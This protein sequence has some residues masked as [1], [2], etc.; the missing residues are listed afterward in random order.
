M[1]KY[2]LPYSAERLELSRELTSKLAQVLNDLHD[3]TYSNRFWQILLATYVNS[4]VSRKNIFEKDSIKIKPLFEPIN[5][6]TSPSIKERGIK[7][8]RRKFKSAKTSKNYQKIINYINENDSI[9]LGLHNPVSVSEDTGAIYLPDYFHSFSKRNDAKRNKLNAIAENTSDL[10]TRNIISQLPE[11]YVEYF[12]EMLNIIPLYNP[13]NKV[14]HTSF[15][16]SFFMKFLVGLYIEN[17]A[18]LHYYQHGAYYGEMI[19]HNAYRNES[20]IADKYITWGWKLSENDVPGKAYRLELFSKKY[21]SQTGNKTYDCLF[22]YSNV[23]P[24]NRENYINYTHALS[25]T[26]DKIKYPRLIARP[27]PMNKIPFVKHKL[28]FPISKDITI[29]SGR[30]DMAELISKGR[31]VIQFTVPSTNFLECFY[32]DH[33]TVGL[34]TN[35]QPTDIIQPYYDFFIAKGVLHLNFDSLI[36]HLNTVDLETWWEALKSEPMYEKFKKE[37]LNPVQ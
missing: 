5:G 29:D 2:L 25:S 18:K 34:L 36:N 24:R 35:D 1:S 33:P 21:K 32:V 3:V 23:T 8:L 14:I 31:V 19:N 22:C 27:R 11:I 9:S 37:F 10:Y 28:N 20:Y 17:G 12:D 16:D 15:I 7:F 26:L 6:V 30:T 13:Q 4:I